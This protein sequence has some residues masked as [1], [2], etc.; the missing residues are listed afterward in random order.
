VGIKN[1]KMQSIQEFISQYAASIIISIVAVAAIYLTIIPHSRGYSPSYCYIT[2]DLYC[3]QML[4]TT[5]SVATDIEIAFTNNLGLS[6]YLPG[7]PAFYASMSS[8]SKYIA[9]QCNTTATGNI[10]KAGAS[11]TCAVSVNTPVTPGSALQPTFY[12]QYSECTNPSCSNYASLPLINTSGSAVA[13]ATPMVGLI[14]STTTINSGGGTTTTINSGGST[15]TTIS[16]GGGGTTTTIN[17][18]SGTTTTISSVS[19]TTTLSTTTTTPTS[20]TTT[21]T[22]T[23]TA[24]P[25]LTQNNVTAVE[26]TIE[27]PIY[28]N[29]AYLP[30]Y[31]YQGA[32][33]AESMGSNPGP[34]I[35]NMINSFAVDLP[36][37]NA[38]LFVSDGLALEADAG[39][40]GTLCAIAPVG[41]YGGNSTIVTAAVSDNANRTNP[42]SG[43]PVTDL[44]SAI[45]NTPVSLTGLSVSPG[46]ILQTDPQTGITTKVESST[47][48]NAIIESSWERTDPIVTYQNTN[49]YGWWWCG[50]PSGKANAT[51]VMYAS[52]Y[53]GGMYPQIGS[54]GSSNYFGTVNY[55]EY[56]SSLWT[57]T[58]T[59]NSTTGSSTTNQYTSDSSSPYWCINGDEAI[60]FL[61]WIGSTEGSSTSPYPSSY[62]GPSPNFTIKD[63]QADVIE[64][65]QWSK[66]YVY[67]NSQS[68]SGCTSLAPG[69]TTLP[70]Y[71][72]TTV[73]GLFEQGQ[74][75]SA[76]EPA[77]CYF[78]NCG[79]LCFSEWA[80]PWVYNSYYSPQGDV[81]SDKTTLS[82]VANQIAP[83][84]LEEGYTIGDTTP[85]SYSPGMC[86]NTEN[87]PTTDL[88]PTEAY[89]FGMPPP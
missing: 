8:G 33:Q 68:I 63:I 60:N 37:N 39:S 9:G 53:G 86:N 36:S 79:A 58:T 65:A 17:P 22:S 75:I 18:G 73:R 24:P 62:S 21:P 45:P 31:G 3:Y 25:V 84:V 42:G 83:S 1:L 87:N 56:N 10:L 72:L 47:P 70:P 41:I 43:T 85:A 51:A 44:C 46:T 20:T 5:N 2:P 50:P 49:P 35:W 14:T 80:L 77:T 23:T 48:P 32:W 26:V 16:P 76:T 15:T 64:T 28:D 7:D 74:T 88:S 59:Y 69:Q 40:A 4:I 54:G 30:G 52:N 11:A 19:S 89:M 71:T 12:L 13:Y 55:G 6:I 81:C 67:A 34:Q 61:G 57:E 66:P 29:G 38:S 82:V 27:E 78:N